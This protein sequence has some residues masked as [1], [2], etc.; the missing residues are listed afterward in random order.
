MKKRK[1]SILKPFLVVLCV[2]IMVGVVALNTNS[3]G[4]ENGAYLATVDQQGSL[5]S[6]GDPEVTKPAVQSG[7]SNLFEQEK[8]SASPVPTAEPTVAPSVVPTKTPEPVTTKVTLAAVGDDLIHS[9]IYKSAKKSNGSYNFDQL[10]LNL[11]DE[12]ASPDIAVINQETVLG[13]ASLGYSGYPRFNS[14]TEVGD[15]VVKAGFDV[16]LHATNHAMDKG[17]K[18]MQNTID[19]WKKY[20]EITVL[21]ANESQDEADTIPVVDVNGI[22]IAMLNYTYGLNGLSLPSGRTYMVNLLDEQRVRSDV[23]KAKEVS[24]FVIVFPHWGT[25][26]VYKPV[27][28]Q[29]EWTQI[30]LETGVDLVIGTHPHVLESVE[31]IEREDGH[32]MLVYYSLGNFVSSQSEV[33]RMLGG[34]ANVTIEKTGEEKAVIADASI[35]QLVTHITKGSKEFTV[36]KLSEYTDSLAA[37]HRLSGKGLNIKKLKSLSKQILGDWYTE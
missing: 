18:G 31:W 37:K 36:Y 24:D 20:P 29:K 8:V 10:F 27:E 35:T 23:A 13:G 25:E 3:S 1:D 15:A 33:P 5:V 30:F 19:F 34:M 7:I 22:R 6:S 28:S 14:P 9:Q 26:Y 32:R 16:V 4:E 17:E 2:M 12:I 11:K 21:G